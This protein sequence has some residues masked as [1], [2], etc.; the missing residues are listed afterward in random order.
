VGVVFGPDIA[1]STLIP[2][3]ATT[4]PASSLRS[5]SA[6]LNASVNAN[7]FAT[8]V[9]FEWGSTT[10]YGQVTPAQNIGSLTTITNVSA[11]VTGLSKG[12]SYHYRVVAVSAGVTNRGD[13]V[14]FITTPVPMHVVVTNIAAQD[15]RFALETGGSVVFACDGVVALS[16]QIEVAN[17]LWIDGTGHSVTFSGSNT[18]RMF[19]VLS[20]VGLALTNVTLADGRSTNGGAIYNEGTVFAQNCRFVNNVAIGSAGANGTNGVAG[21]NSSN[22]QLV[23]PGTDAGGGNPGQSAAGGAI[24]SGGVLGLFQCRF[25]GNKVFGGSGGVGGEGGAGGRQVDGIFVVGGKAGG[26]GGTGGNGGR[27]SGGAIGS[28]GNLIVD[29]CQ[30]SISWV[31]G[32]NGGIGGA[33]GR[34]GFLGV[35][36]RGGNGGTGGLSQGGA[37][38]GEGNA[39]ILNSAFVANQASGG[40]GGDGGRTPSGPPSAP[41]GN[42]GNAGAAFGGCIMNESNLVLINCTLVTNTI[43]GGRGGAGFCSTSGGNGGDALGGGLANDGDLRATNVTM[44]GNVAL[45]GVII[46]NIG[47]NPSC[48]LSRPPNGTNGSIFG[49]SIANSGTFVLANSILTFGSSNNSYGAITDGGDNISSDAT[50]AWTSGSSSNNV[51][52]LLLPLANNGGPTLTMALRVGSPALNA[53]DPATS[54]ATDQRGYPRPVGPAPDIGAYEGLGAPA[55]EIIR[56]SSATNMIRWFAE[57]ARVY[58]L[59]QTSNLRDWTPVATNTVG[60]DGFLNFPVSANPSPRFFRVVAQ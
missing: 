18:S 34:P 56:E 41:L 22:S 32:G 37:I 36:G 1:F 60:A 16:N 42:G 9:F 54:P 39:V 58:R 29:Q 30:F 28:F 8:T 33:G 25:D 26:S 20:G 7:G 55:L 45:G 44:N 13:D 52:P 59:E 4:Q 27:A 46:T 51:D 47:P 38:Y 53:A 24:W 50:P 35:G 21:T 12:L 43:T 48:T 57:S 3:S 10:N 40:N 31:G 6:V 2:S 14:A 17:N 19:S 5:T 49:G 23:T 15:V 11:L